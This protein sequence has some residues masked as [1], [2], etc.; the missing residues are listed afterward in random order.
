MPVIWGPSQYIP[1]RIPRAHRARAAHAPDIQIGGPSF[2][3]TGPNYW[4]K[5][6]G[7]VRGT[8]SRGCPFWRGSGCPSRLARAFCTAAAAIEPRS[9]F[10]LSLYSRAL[11]VRGVAW[12]GRQRVPTAS[13]LAE[14]D[15]LELRPAHMLH[16]RRKTRGPDLG[17]NFVGFLWPA[18]RP[19]GVLAPS[20]P[21]P[22]Q[23]AAGQGR[24]PPPL[25][26]LGAPTAEPRPPRPPKLHMFRRGF[27]PWGRAGDS[28][29]L[30]FIAIRASPRARP[31]RCEPQPHV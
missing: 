28:Q 25:Q 24:P 21:D 19:G 1:A 11:R 8:R 30:I 15:A 12:R 6:P 23:C 9:D 7:Y 2:L 27:H 3:L 16:S 18:F 20:P 13:K 29:P 22:S 4:A 10:A 26:S 17:P 31:Q 14:D 5:R